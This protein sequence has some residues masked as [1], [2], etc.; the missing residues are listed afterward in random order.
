MEGDKVDPPCFDSRL[1]HVGLLFGNTK[2]NIMAA[3]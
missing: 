1:G 2:E 3:S